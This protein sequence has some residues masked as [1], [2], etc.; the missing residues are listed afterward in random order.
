MEGVKE[1]L[2]ERYDFPECTQC[3]CKPLDEK[4]GET[5]KEAIKI[6]LAGPIIGGVGLASFQRDGSLAAVSK[7]LS[8]AG[9]DELGDWVWEFSRTNK[10]GEFADEHFFNDIEWIER[11]GETYC[12]KCK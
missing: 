3:A 8:K 10:V 5:G 4:Y 2:Y 6:G 1:K 11:D 7:I 9:Y 12:Y